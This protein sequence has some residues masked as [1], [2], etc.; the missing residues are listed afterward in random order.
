MFLKLTKYIRD[1]ENPS[2]WAIHYT[3]SQIIWQQIGN[4]GRLIQ[5]QRAVILK[6]VCSH[7]VLK[8]ELRQYIW[9]FNNHSPRFV[10]YIFTT[11]LCPQLP[12]KSSRTVKISRLQK[13]NFDKV[14]YLLSEEIFKWYFRGKLLLSPRS[15]HPT[16]S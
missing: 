8:N 6:I 16:A 1:K 12:W 13:V 11:A 14:K 3:L 9:S 7:A 5:L 2:R 15:L 4:V 10:M